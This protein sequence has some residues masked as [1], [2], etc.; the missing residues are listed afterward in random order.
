MSQTPHFG[1]ATAEHF[2]S[3]NNGRRPLVPR[4]PGACRPRIR[5]P[6]PR[7][8]DQEP[9]QARFARDSLLEGTRFEPSVPPD[10]SSGGGTYPADNR[11]D[12]STLFSS[13]ARRWLRATRIRS[14]SLPDPATSFANSRYFLP[15][16]RKETRIHKWDQ[17]FE[18][19]FLQRRV[20]CEPEFSGATRT[21]GPNWPSQSLW[22]IAA[23]MS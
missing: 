6:K 13:G 18:S 17:E 4:Y 21:G 3:V 1:H 15:V 23:G 9:G 7:L 12:G 5:P 11:S 22:D 2:L 19:A 10:R 20:Y 14:A 8:C 16:S